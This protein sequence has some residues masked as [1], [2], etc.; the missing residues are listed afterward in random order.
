MNNLDKIYNHVFTL[1]INDDAPPKDADKKNYTELEY[2]VN[3]TQFYFVHFCHFCP[4]WI[5]PLDY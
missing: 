3:N 5:M 1:E 2:Y 4:S